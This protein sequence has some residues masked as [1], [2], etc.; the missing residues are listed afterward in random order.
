M[1]TILCLHTAVS[2]HMEIKLLKST[3]AYNDGVGDLGGDSVGDGMEPR[4][5]SDCSWLGA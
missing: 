2:G 1:L 3:V 5:G 4:S